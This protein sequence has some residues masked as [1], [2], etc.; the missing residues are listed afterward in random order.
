MSKLRSKSESDP[1]SIA[2]TN[3]QVRPALSL[4]NGKRYDDFFVGFGQ[5]FNTGPFADNTYS[6]REV[7]LY[8]SQAGEEEEE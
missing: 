4:R 7:T 3:Q 5:I 1:I 6:K 2:N 8:H